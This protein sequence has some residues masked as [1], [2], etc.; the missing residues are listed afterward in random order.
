[1]KLKKTLILFLSILNN[2]KVIKARPLYQT[3][4][5]LQFYEIIKSGTA[6]S[7]DNEIAFL[8]DGTIIE[9]NVYTVPDYDKRSKI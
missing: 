8:S 9:K 6:E 1:M 2:V 4:G 5:K 7:I 3:F